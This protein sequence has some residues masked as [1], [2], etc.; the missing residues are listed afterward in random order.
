LL[1]I[2]VVAS[3]YIVRFQLT[4]ALGDGYAQTIASIINAIVIQITNYTYNLVA[5]SLTDHENHRTNTEYEDQIILKI[6]V[7]QF[8][9]S[10]A[11][12]YYLAFV[13]EPVGDCPN[14]DCMSS[15]AINLGIIFATRLVTKNLFD[16]VIPYFQYKWNCYREYGHADIPPFIRSRL[17]RP[18]K[19]YL[20]LKVS[21]LWI[22]NGNCINGSFS[23]QHDTAEQSITQYLEIVLQFGYT[24]LFATV[25][26]ISALFAHISCI[27]SIKAYTYKILHFQQRC[28]PYGAQDI[29]TWQSVFL[30][31]AVVAVATNAG[32]TVFTMDALNDYSNVFRFWVFILFQWVCYLLQVSST[33]CILEC[34]ITLTDYWS[35]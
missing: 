9:N 14:D 28:F 27:I 20:L 13:A 12:F 11:S 22:L 24:A 29:G 15:L 7:F 21:S 32:L 10:Y 16:L 1:V 33:I 4:D 34:S 17:S 2:G 26:P 5:I 6:F 35:L 19:D 31:I 25:L 3:I 18:E 8:I 23:F 30:V